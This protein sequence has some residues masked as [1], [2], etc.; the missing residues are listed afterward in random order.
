MGRLPKYKDQLVNNQYPL[1]EKSISKISENNVFELR[2]GKNHI[3][4]ILLECIKYILHDTNIIFYPDLKNSIEDEQSNSITISDQDSSNSVAIHIELNCE[5]F[6]HYFCDK[7]VVAGVNVSDLFKVIKSVDKDDIIF[8]YMEKNNESQLFISTENSITKEITKTVLE[9]RECEDEGIE[10][11]EM[12]F[13]ISLVVPSSRF[14]KICKDLNSFGTRAIKIEVI[15]KKII[16]TSIG[17]EV[18]RQV[19]LQGDNGGSVSD[20]GSAYMYRGVFMLKYFM[21]FIKATP[22]SDKVEFF[23]KNDN[24]LMIKYKVVNLGEICFISSQLEEE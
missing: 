22:L 11:P 18:D 2:T 8:I 7:K 9:T 14:Q 21:D 6:E 19:I 16:F 4:R 24:P 17:G 15:D 5:E 1:V 10:I 12:E 23:L 20:T 3:I 13:D